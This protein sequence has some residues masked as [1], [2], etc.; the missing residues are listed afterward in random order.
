MKNFGT[1]LRTVTALAA[2]AG[3]LALAGCASLDQNIAAS[4]KQYAVPGKVMHVADMNNYP[5]CEIGLITGTA[6]VYLWRE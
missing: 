2:L 6:L 5:F 3:V 1:T 4:E